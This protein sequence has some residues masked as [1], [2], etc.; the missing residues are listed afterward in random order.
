MN[1]RQLEYFKAIAE[2][3]QITAAARR[4]HITQPPLSYELA[5]LERELGTKLVERSSRGTELTEAGRVLYQRACQMLDLAEATKR[6]VGNVGRGLAGTLSVGLISSSGGQV[7]NNAL[8]EL[9]KSYPD[10]QLQLREGSTYEVLDMLRRGVV[11]IGIV[12]ML[13]NQDEFECRLSGAE[14]MAALMPP[15]C[16]CGAKDD[17][18]TLAE[19][20]GQPLVIYRRYE[21]VLTDLFASKDLD[22]YFACIA[23]DA[24]TTCVWAS[25]GFGIGLV[26]QSFLLLFNLDGFV[27]KRVDE[28]ALMTRMGV[29]WPKGKHLSPLAQRFVDLLWSGEEIQA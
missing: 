28:E 16:V 22:H 23:D 13:S 21:K 25:R 20:A 4:L 27:V 24:R 14:P 12:R 3:R 7:P 26:P 17:S 2:E 6:E 15:E 10:V 9:T 8:L 1:L 29:V 5:S 19:L 11:E 18:V